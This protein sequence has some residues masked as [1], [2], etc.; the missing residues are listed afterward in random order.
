MLSLLSHVPEDPFN[1]LMPA[2]PPCAFTLNNLR[3]LEPTLSSCLE[4]RKLLGIH[5]PKSGTWP[6]NGRGR[7]IINTPCPLLEMRITPNMLSPDLTCDW[8]KVLL[9]GTLLAITHLLMYFLEI[10]PKRSVS[11]ESL[12]QDLFLRSVID[13]SGMASSDLHLLVFLPSYN[14]L[15]WVWLAS[16]FKAD[17]CHFCD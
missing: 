14:S 7:G 9:H 15:L 13:S 11:N 4:S 17:W 10:L 2:S 3:L 8:A 1:T 5:V 12:F 6:R 16:E